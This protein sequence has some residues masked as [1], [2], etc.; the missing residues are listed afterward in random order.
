LR[1][2]GRPIATYLAEILERWTAEYGGPVDPEEEKI[3]WDVACVAAV[4]DPESVTVERRAL[5]TLDAAAAHD[6]SLPGREV[7][8]VSD[9][10]ERR[11]L[12]GLVEALERLPGEG[13]S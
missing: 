8:M 1:G 2:F 11:V 4:A 7:E 13:R 5:P 3:L 6:Y 12:A 10:D 9:L